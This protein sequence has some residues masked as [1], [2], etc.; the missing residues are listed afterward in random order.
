MLDSS[1][2]DYGCVVSKWWSI[3][4]PLIFPQ[5][6]NFLI[7]K[8][9]FLLKKHAATWYYSNFKKWSQK[10]SLRNFWT[11]RPE[12]H[13]LSRWPIQTQQPQ[14]PPQ[15]PRQSQSRLDNGTLSTVLMH[16]KVKG[17]LEGL[18]SILKRP[19]WDFMDGT[20]VHIHGYLGEAP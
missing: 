17:R 16:L 14:Q 20:M 5:L 19:R 6:P 7:F 15:P 3:F 12:F 8:G 13:Q 9:C 10:Y 11:T 1:T 2:M 18:A 4:S